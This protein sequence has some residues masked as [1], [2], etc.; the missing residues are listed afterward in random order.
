MRLASEIEKYIPVN[1]QEENDKEIILD[2][3]KKN[4]DCFTREN[5]IAHFTGIYFSISLANLIFF[6]FYQIIYTE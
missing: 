3:M 2:Y 4:P 1:E 5:Q 6:L